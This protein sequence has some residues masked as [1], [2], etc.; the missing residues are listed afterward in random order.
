M[1]GV[2]VLEPIT[3]ETD[4]YK[5][6][7]Y[8]ELQYGGLGHYLYENEWDAMNTAWRLNMVVQPI[9]YI[10]TKENK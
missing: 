4:Y 9:H 10:N 2:K 8:Y 5:T 6:G 7:T 1:F 3:K